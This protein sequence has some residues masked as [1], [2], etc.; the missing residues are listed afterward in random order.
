MR[1][2]PDLATR[3]KSAGR[4]LPLARQAIVSS[5][6][7]QTSEVLRRDPQDEARGQDLRGLDSPKR[8]L[9]QRSSLT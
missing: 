8:C 1:R 5:E 3:S 9:S 6:V 7:Q 2:H 4:N